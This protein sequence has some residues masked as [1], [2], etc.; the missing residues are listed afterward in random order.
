MDSMINGSSGFSVRRL[1]VGGTLLIA[2]LFVLVTSAHAKS[3]V[4][5][6]K[7]RLAVDLDVAFRYKPSKEDVARWK[8]IFSGAGY[9]LHRATNG[10]FYLRKVVL[11]TCPESTAGKD[12]RAPASAD[13]AITRL[14]QGGSFPG[15]RADTIT[16][17]RSF[18]M[19]R[20]S[21]SRLS[22]RQ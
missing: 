8:S 6:G 13:I 3:P 19:R 14:S 12:S 10:W 4:L 17:V 16:V 21:R 22:K 1:L 20:A 9:R 7:G 11:Y 2:G 5:D 18:S 15:P